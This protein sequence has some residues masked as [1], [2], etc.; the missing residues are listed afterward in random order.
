MNPVFLFLAYVASLGV[1]LFVMLFGESALFVGTPVATAHW[2]LN[3][4]VFDAFWRALR[5]AFDFYRC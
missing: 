4:G 1:F 5:P 3:H 2:W